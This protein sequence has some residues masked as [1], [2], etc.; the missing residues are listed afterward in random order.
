VTANDSVLMGGG[1]THSRKMDLQNTLLALGSV[2]QLRQGSR[3]GS[4]IYGAIFNV[5]KNDLLQENRRQNKPIEEGK[6]T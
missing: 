1:T 2:T 3:T 5:P 6:D 4:G